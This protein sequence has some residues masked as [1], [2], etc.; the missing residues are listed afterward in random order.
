MVFEHFRK[1][2][3]ITALHFKFSLPHVLHCY[4]FHIY[5]YT[6]HLYTCQNRS[7]VFTLSEHVMVDH[8]LLLLVSSSQFRHSECFTLF[9]QKLALLKSR[10][11]LIRPFI[12]IRCRNG[13][14]CSWVWVGPCLPFVCLLMLDTALL[15]ILFTSFYV[16]H[17]LD[18]SH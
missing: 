6:M 2:K 10:F 3:W 7:I 5:P 9:G 8:F 18:V 17:S 15:I 14:S 16:L 1:R 11:E 12:N 4:L 13:S